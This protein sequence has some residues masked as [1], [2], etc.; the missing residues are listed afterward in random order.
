M[1]KLLVALSLVCLAGAAFSQ[2]IDPSQI[3]LSNAKLSVAGPDSVY[4]RSIG[5]QGQLLS[6]L[7]QFDGLSG[8]KIYG[9]YFS[10]TKLMQDSY[11]LEYATLRIQGGDTIIVSD[12]IL[13]GNGYSGRLKYDGFD[14]LTLENFWESMSPKTTDMRIAELTIQIQAA[15]K[16][17]EEQIAATKAKYEADLADAEAERDAMQDA[18]AMAQAAAAKAGVEISTLVPAVSSVPTKTELSG[19][20]NTVGEY[21]SWSASANRASQSDGSLYYAK[22]LIPLRQNQSQLLYSFSARAGGSGYVGYGLHFFVSDD[23]DANSYGLGK[24]YL[25]WLTRDPGYYG[26]NRTYLQVYESFGDTK[27]IQVASVTIPDAISST[28][29]TDIL[30]DKDRGNISVRVNGDRYLDYEVSM[31]LARGN[32][33]ALRTLGSGVVFTQL[34]VKAQ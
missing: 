14:G 25:V 29:Q 20:S 13:G 10:G 8:A 9:P 6:V 1:K 34:T 16:N 27:M 4:V 31:P 11:E 26:S 17:Y 18:L 19:F 32:K 12:L 22:Y 15:K 33:I 28:N 7:L 23:R 21:G 3:D 24:S 30:Y 5:Y 2:P